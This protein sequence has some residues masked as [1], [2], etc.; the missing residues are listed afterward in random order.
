MVEYLELL[1]VLISCP[2]NCQTIADILLLPT[3]KTAEMLTSA[4]G[5]V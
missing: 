5:E 1:S 3:K 4:P 2:L